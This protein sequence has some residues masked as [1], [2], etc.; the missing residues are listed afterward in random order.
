MKAA[1]SAGETSRLLQSI[2][3]LKENFGAEMNGWNGKARDEWMDRLIHLKQQM[4]E[5]MK[6]PEK[7]QWQRNSSSFKEF[8]EFLNKSALRT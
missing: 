2:R 4:E 5:E 8:Q 3:T 6:E 7:N 1:R